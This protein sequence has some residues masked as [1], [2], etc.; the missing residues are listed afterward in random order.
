[1]SNFVNVNDVMRILEIRKI[2]AN[3]IIKKLNAELKEQVYLIVNGKVHKKYFQSKLYF[4]I[5]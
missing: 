1:M 3:Q 5:K 4:E 2:L